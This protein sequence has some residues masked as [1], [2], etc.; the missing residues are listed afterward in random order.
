MKNI[1]LSIDEKVLAKVRVL[2]AQENTTV[3]AMVRDFLAKRAEDTAIIAERKAAAARMLE[4]SRNSGAML[5]DGWQLDREK[6]YA[7]RISGHEHPD[8]CGGGDKK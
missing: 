5:P 1:T 2:A 8:L 7:E 6:I 4:M 3:N